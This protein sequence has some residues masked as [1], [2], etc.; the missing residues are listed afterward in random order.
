[1]QWVS[2]G[3]QRRVALARLT[4]SAAR[5]LWILDEPFSS[6]DESALERLSARITRHLVSGGV[7]VY[8]THQNV[9]LDAPVN[10]LELGKFPVF[11]RM[12]KGFLN[13]RIKSY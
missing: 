6:L 11:L 5:K 10:A 9:E 8:A 4:F 2:A 1:M 13:G 3:Q 7:V 12:V